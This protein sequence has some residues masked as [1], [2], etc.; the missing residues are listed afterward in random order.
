MADDDA[1]AIL[2]RVTMWILVQKMTYMPYEEENYDFQLFSKSFL[3]YHLGTV[4]CKQ[5]TKL[6]SYTCLRS[7]KPD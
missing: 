3:P 1:R 5:P 4:L 2:R 7:L 6:I